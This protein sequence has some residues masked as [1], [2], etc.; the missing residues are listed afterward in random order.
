MLAGDLDQII[1]GQA[2]GLG[3]DWSGN[4]DL[5]VAGQPPDHLDRRIVDRRKRVAQLGQSLGLD[6]LDQMAE[7]V[8]EQADLRL[9][10]AIGVVE[11]QVGDTSERLD[12]FLGRAA[13]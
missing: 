8:V 1:R 4:R 9:V 5:V 3:Q 12:A 13:L 7:N 6:P 11:K 10:K 2:R